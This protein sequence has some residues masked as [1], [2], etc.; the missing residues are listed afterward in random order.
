M[1]YKSGIQQAHSVGFFVMKMMLAADNKEYKENY[2]LYN[3]ML[4]LLGNAEIGEQL[5]MFYVIQEGKLVEFSALE[6]DAP[7]NNLTRTIDKPTKS[8]Y[9]F[10]VV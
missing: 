4:P 1:R 10:L 7:A 3:K 2:D 8:F 6:Y 9:D 5:C